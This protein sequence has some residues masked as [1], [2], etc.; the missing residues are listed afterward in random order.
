MLVAVY[1]QKIKDLQ[2]KYFQYVWLCNDI[3]AY[4]RE[5]PTTDTP[6]PSIRE[7][8]SDVIQDNRCNNSVRGVRR[9][10]SS[11]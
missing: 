2:E 6:L 3:F 5:P 1:Y 8:N 9:C 10:M 11:N 7:V 4:Y